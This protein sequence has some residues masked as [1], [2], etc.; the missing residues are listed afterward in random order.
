MTSMDLESLKHV[1]LLGIGGESVSSVALFFHKLGLEVV[2]YDIN[3]SSRTIELG[4]IGIH[5]NYKNPKSLENTDLVI[6]SDAIP[7]DIIQEIKAKNRK[8]IFQEIGNFINQLL[9]K[10]ED[11]ILTKDQQ[12]AFKKSGIA[13]L[14]NI[15]VNSQKLIAVT[16]TDGKS[17]VCE[18]IYHVLIKHGYRPGMIS[19]LGC[20]IGRHKLHTGLHTTTPS[21]KEIQRLLTEM[22]KDHCSHIIIECTSQG[23]FMGRLAGL[24]FDVAV[25]T[26]ITHE[27][28]NYHKTWEEYAAAK[29]LLIQR[30]LNKNGAMIIN[31]D[32][33]RSYS[34]LSALHTP[35]IS[36][37]TKDIPSEN[38]VFAVHV[39]S[40][41]APELS[42]RYK[43]KIY[44]LPLF[45]TYNIS[46]A[47]AAAG[48]LRTLGIPIDT[49][50]STL[51]SYPGL[52]G[53]MQCI[54][55]HPFW[56][57][58]DFAHTP[59]ALKSA[60]VTVRNLTSDHGKIISVFGC[61]SQRDDL[62]RPI[63]GEIAKRYADITI[64]TAEDPRIEPLHQIND[65][66]EEGWNRIRNAG[67]SLVRYD[68][69]SKNFE[70]RR[71]AIDKALSLAKAGDVV[72]ITGKGHERSLCFGSIEYPWSDISETKKL[73]Q[74]RY[75]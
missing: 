22:K 70:V 50:L 52:P 15:K 20:K 6:Y 12:A 47:L 60:M 19:T 7:S 71:K 56:V 62:K 26:N 54:Q 55:R 27:H 41:T 38:D 46:N 59:N 35:T 73:L 1:T 74:N 63:M 44:S 17:T 16:G 58:I 4:K 48:C 14:Y 72:L 9:Q 32:D 61:A 24:Q 5:I 11:K 23:L 64:L 43:H 45:G 69:D 57:I 53:R 3:K 37:S 31:K 51:E 18:M 28:M 10:K 75:A 2:G 42:F 13:P 21:S 66:I 30:H 36:Y 40:N 65:A 25:F 8:L 68:D 49:S 67:H 34:Y 33:K 39:M 29:A